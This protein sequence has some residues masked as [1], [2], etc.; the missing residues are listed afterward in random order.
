MCRR[1][2][3]KQGQNL[4]VHLRDTRMVFLISCG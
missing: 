1:T 2:F 4:A 3:D